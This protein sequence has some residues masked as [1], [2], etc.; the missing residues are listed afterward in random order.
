MVP[1]RLNKSP[2]VN[3]M[4]LHLLSVYKTDHKFH[5]IK[6]SYS[7]LTFREDITNAS[8]IFS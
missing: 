7:T 5:R 2:R 4:R 3:C 6:K 8:A 1:V